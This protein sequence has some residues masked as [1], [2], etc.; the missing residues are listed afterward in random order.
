MNE[1]EFYTI[2]NVDNMPSADTNIVMRLEFETSSDEIIHERAVYTVLDLLGDLGGLLDMLSYLAQF[3]V[4]IITRVSGSEI[5]RYMISLIFLRD[6]VAR[7]GEQEAAKE[8]QSQPQ[9]VF[10]QM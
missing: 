2:D 9:K 6:K 4:T 3:I 7:W 8:V 5:L 1:Q 10:K